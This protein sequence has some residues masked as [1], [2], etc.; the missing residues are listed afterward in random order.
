MLKLAHKDLDVWNFSK[1]LVMEIYR[2]TSCFP[3]EELFGLTNQL[4]RASVSVISNFAE[5]S[6]RKSFI[7]R[8]RFYEISRSS[9]VEIDTQIEIS[10]SLGLVKN[11]DIK[12]LEEILNH[13]FAMISKMIVKQP[14][15]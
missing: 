13:L 4:R 8:K 6:A 12:N 9:I 1:Q 3:K 15:D 10:I 14:I 11:E 5:G 7:E 2:I